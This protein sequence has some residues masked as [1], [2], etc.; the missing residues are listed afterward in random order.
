[1]PTVPKLATMAIMSQFSPRDTL[2]NRLIVVG[3]LL[4]I[5]PC[6]LIVVAA[7]VYGWP[8]VWSL[9]P[10]E[11]RP[12]VAAQ[13]GESLVIVAGLAGTN[14]IDATEQIYQAL[15]D[16]SGGASYGMGA[17][18]G[19]RMGRLGDIPLSEQDARSLGQEYN[20]SVVL[21]GKF[22]DSENIEV[23][24][25]ILHPKADLE[26]RQF[27]LTLAHG[28]TA[29]ID[30]LATIVLS[31]SFYHTG[32]YYSVDTLLNSLGGSLD[33][34]IVALY[35][36]ESYRALGDLAR[37]LSTVDAAL[38]GDPENALLLTLKASILHDLARYDEAL[39]SASASLE[40]EPD[41]VEAYLVRGSVYQQ[42][43]DYQNA[44]ADAS[45]VLELAPENH[46]ALRARAQA[47]EKLGETQEAL[48]DYQALIE[49]EP[50]NYLNPLA[51]AQLYATIG[52]KD[53][54]LADF[55]Q[56]LAQADKAEVPDTARQQVLEAR[57]LA[58]RDFGKYT[59]ALADYDELASIDGTN[60]QHQLERG[61]T[62]WE[63]GDQPQAEHEWD[64]Y[65]QNSGY[66]QDASGYNN[67]AWSLAMAGHFGPALNYSNQS[68]RL[69]PR[70][71]NS[72][73]TRGY[74]LLM[75]KE[76]QAALVDFEEAIQNGLDYA[77]V[78]RDMADAYF[79]LGQY[80]QAIEN[81]R[82]YLHL[83]PDPADRYQVEQ[84][85]VAAQA[86]FQP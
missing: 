77:P 67:L 74:I 35:R 25:S 11:Q 4:L 53:A 18:P 81:Y 39:E 80:E 36:I 24:C 56:A 14:G 1:M 78:Y 65:M 57:A 9:L 8:L 12:V 51:R 79:G 85:I 63:M 76:Y 21:W 15:L 61:M 32:N 38:S 59:L 3:C 45:R 43:G 40:Q 73:H 50:D 34:A 62:Y 48:E 2:A 17:S 27:T 49:R 23:T 70:D 84:R 75:Q 10:Q 55:A 20:A 68:L 31:I 71:P 33:P 13:P 86:A 52:D 41:W 19:V 72:L 66:A 82:S 60:I 6:L 26:P 5:V 58:Y 83:T 30:D 16:V 47:Y 54:A 37:A 69:D 42:M 22:D 29:A 44:L 7:A 28:D 64:M 46:R